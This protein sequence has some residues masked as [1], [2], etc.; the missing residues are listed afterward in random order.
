MI[1]KY[2]KDF[3]KKLKAN[4]FYRNIAIVASGNIAARLLT[5][6]L[7]PIITRIYSPADYGIYNVFMSII[8]ITGALV[9]LRYSV[10][11][12]VARDEKLADNLLKLCFIITIVLSLLWLLLVLLF[13]EYLSK[14]FESDSL[15]S[16]LW[17]IPIVFFGKGI[18][19]ALNNWAV[20]YRDFKL[21]THTKLTQSV[22][23][24]LVKIG[25]GLI[26]VKPLGLLIGHIVSE[27]AGIANIFSKL[28]KTRPDF[29]KEFSPRA[30]KTAAIR[31]KRFPLVQ[32]WSQL[33]LSA[34]AQLPV[35]LL[36]YYHGAAIVG[37]FGLANTMIRMPMD[38][39]G[40]SVSQV[41]FGEISIFGK[42]NPT[43]IYTLTI[44]LIRR[45]LIIGIIPIALIAIFGP[46]V[47]SL[48]FG[49]QWA[50]AGLYARL[51]SIYVLF[52]FIS[53]PVANIFNVYE[54]MD[55][56]LSLNIFRVIVVTLVFVFSGY[57]G[58][59]P[60][61]TIGNYSICLSFYYLFL[62][63][64]VIKLIKSNL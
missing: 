22:S 5:I 39:L 36:G 49:P 63:I 8:G 4:T 44:S 64:R 29:F 50:D 26:N 15:E 43:K 9:T 40:Q 60:L 12:P 21:I 57:F 46:W 16:F 7:T 31:Y 47:F 38:L 59:S 61:S 48:I 10:T 24:S 35:L 41:Y 28:I 51:L 45:L 1:T 20:R 23:S 32:S 37:I 18:Y 52:A 19:E 6:L 54:R 33:F 2:F 30:I 42:E 3:W 27:T 13:G 62:V 14:H 11:I 25:L 53:A 56:Q 58:F 34:G 55:I 17:L